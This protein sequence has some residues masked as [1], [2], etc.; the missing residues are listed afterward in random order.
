MLKTDPGA[1]MDVSI[2]LAISTSGAWLLLFRGLESGLW[3]G[4][5]AGLC[6][7]DINGEVGTCNTLSCQKGLL[8][9]RRRL[10]YNLH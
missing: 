2:A 6:T 4:E 9:R 10:M 7:G 5:A 8:L 1:R 3:A